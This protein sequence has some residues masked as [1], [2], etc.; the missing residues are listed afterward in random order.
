MKT[1]GLKFS[2]ELKSKKWKGLDVECGNIV[3]TVC[4]LKLYRC[5]AVDW[6]FYEV[7]HLY[8]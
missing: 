5:E 7:I 4:S 3:A 8:E 6:R 1:Y 2:Y